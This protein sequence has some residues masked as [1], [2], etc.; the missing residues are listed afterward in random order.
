VAESIIHIYLPGGMSA[1]ESLD[2]KPLAPLE[3]RGAFGAIKTRTPGMQISELMPNTAR[4]TDKIA[5]I[6]SIT[7]GE[8]AHERGTHTMFTGYRPSPAVQYPSFGSVVSH[9]VGVRNDLPPYICVPRQPN[10]YA[11]SGYLSNAFGPFSVGAEPT[12]KNF[13]VR[14]LNL[15]NGVDAARF[16]RRRSMLDA[17][18]KSDALSSMDSFY[19]RAYSLISSKSAREA[20]DLSAEPDALIEAYGKNEAGMRMLLARRLAESG[21]RFISLT[22]G[23]WDHH[24]RIAEGFR[25]EMPAFDKAFATLIQD[26]ADRK[27]L[28]KTLVMVS[29]EFGR[30]PKIDAEAEGRGHWPRCF[31][32]ILAGGGIKGGIVYGSSDPVGAEPVDNP[33]SVEDFAATVYNRIGIDSNKTLESPGGRPV[34][35]IRGGRVV[36]DLLA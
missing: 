31:S 8:A 13:S 25:A 17:V 34:D 5:V 23:G 7:H 22:Y 16:D 12:G 2:P 32:V 10:P 29:S 20:F 11:G 4:I 15:P 36:E 9:E 27:M 1:Q 33:L 30:S 6:R 28:S 18:E 14:D 26:L 21:V 24:Q 3:N 19:E 35:I